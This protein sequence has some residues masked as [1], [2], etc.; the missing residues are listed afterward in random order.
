MVT[1]S[2]KRRLL[3]EYREPVDARGALAKAAVGLLIVAGLALIGATYPVPEEPSAEVSSKR[4][5]SG[6]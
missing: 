3:E 6:R 4:V 1:S 2:E 5:A